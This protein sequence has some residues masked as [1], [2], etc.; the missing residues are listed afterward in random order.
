MEI[1][2]YRGAIC[3][4]QEATYTVPVRAS[5]ELIGSNAEA[6]AKNRFVHKG[7]LARL[8]NRTGFSALSSGN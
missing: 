6:Q 8:P 7:Y 3:A 2:R 5:A 1:D 4:A